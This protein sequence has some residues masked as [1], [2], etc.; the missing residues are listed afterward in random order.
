[1]INIST[2][3][4]KCNASSRFIAASDSTESTAAATSPSTT[5]KCITYASHIVNASYLEVVLNR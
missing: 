2:V 3:S 5:S 1:M 4:G